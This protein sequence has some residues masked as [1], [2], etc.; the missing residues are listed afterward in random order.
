MARDWI[1]DVLQEVADAINGIDDREAHAIRSAI[2]SN[3]PTQKTGIA[4][5]D[6]LGPLD[7]ERRRSQPWVSQLLHHAALFE[8][9][10]RGEY[11][12]VEMSLDIL[13][14]LINRYVP[15]ARKRTIG[16]RINKIWDDLQ[17]PGKLMQI[18]APSGK[19]QLDIGYVVTYHDVEAAICRHLGD[20]DM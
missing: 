14:A 8:K 9:K 17:Q 7:Q 2:E 5:L 10:P 13:R 15:S 19:R 1:D 18:E 3:L 20:N 6:I 11:V 16:E 4:E 12:V